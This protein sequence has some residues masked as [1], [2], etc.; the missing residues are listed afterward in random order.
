MKV[1]YKYVCMHVRE[2]GVQSIQLIGNIANTLKL[3]AQ[4]ATEEITSCMVC[5]YST[6]YVRTYVCMHVH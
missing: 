3:H 1:Q 6:T 2:T 4:M 5:A